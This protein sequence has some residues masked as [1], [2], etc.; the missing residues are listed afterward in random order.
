MQSPLRI[1]RI[2]LSQ[3]QVFWREVG[4]GTPIIFLHGAYADSSQWLPVIDRL[5]ERYH[6]F[7]PDLLGCGESK[8]PDIHQSIALQVECLAEYIEALRLERPYLVGHSL[9]GWV[10]A[11]YAA[12]YG[13]RLQGLVLIAPEGMEVEG[14]EGRW[15]WEKLLIVRLPFFFGVLK[16]IAPLAGLLRLRT[17]IDELSQHRT[18]LEAHPATCQL[19]F[20]RPYT[21]IQPE[22]L[23]QKLAEFRRPTLILQGGR[24]RA[25]NLA[26]SKVYAQAIAT[27]KLRV[28]K[29][30]DAN[31]I[32]SWPDNTAREIQGFTS[33][34]VSIS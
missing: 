10:A 33:V 21:E 24:D 25:I 26:Q 17:K 12:K 9:G 16:A 27:A 15:D 20:D 34:P 5:E 2:Q 22:F 32:A 19:L 1:S 14:Q 31:L 29:N 11:S 23:N 4:R 30:G 13:D 18:L 28:M 8:S 6:C 7:A 3:G